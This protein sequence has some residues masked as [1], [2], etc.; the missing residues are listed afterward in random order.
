MVEPNYKAA[1]QRWA[2]Q[3]NITP[4]AFAAKMGY[5]YNHAYQILNGKLDVS[6][7]LMGRLALRYSVHDLETIIRMANGLVGRKSDDVQGN[8]CIAEV[9]QSGR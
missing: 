4:T 5:T 9:F 2:T 7:A 3:A 1:I 8:M 6:E